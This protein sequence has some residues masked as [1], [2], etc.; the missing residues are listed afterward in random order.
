MPVSIAGTCTLACSNADIR[1]KF[2][3][4]PQG[5]GR[6]ASRCFFMGQ[7]TRSSAMPNK[8]APEYQ[9]PVD[10]PARRPEEAEV[11]SDNRARQAVPLGRMRYVLAISLALAIGGFIVLYLLLW[12]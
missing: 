9:S 2:R 1:P 11:V 3:I 12:S 4:L 7:A 10:R 5:T 8:T 6:E